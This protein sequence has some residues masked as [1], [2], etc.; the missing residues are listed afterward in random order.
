[1]EEEGSEPKRRAIAS[2]LTATLTTLQQHVAD[3][4]AKR[5]KCM[6]PLRAERCEEGEG[7]WGVEKRR[8]E[9][10]AYIEWGVRQRALEV[11]RRR[12]I[13][14][15]RFRHMMWAWLAARRC[16][17][18]TTRRELEQMAAA[19]EELGLGRSARVTAGR[20]AVEHALAVLG[21][22][23]GRRRPQYRE[24]DDDDDAMGGEG[25]G[26]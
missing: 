9:A 15:R 11:M 18:E 16:D 8:R 23:G 21:G 26:V 13:Q 7:W 4:L 22:S 25:G 10:R 2:R 3:M 6:G 5:E 19:E 24:P 17:G 20:R 12:R 1:M 14:K